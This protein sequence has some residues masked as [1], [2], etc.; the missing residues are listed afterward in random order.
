MAQK[1][2]EIILLRQLAGYLSN[3]IL[4]F[5]PAGDLLYF[6]EPAEALLGQRFEESGALT[7]AQWHT[8][9]DATHEDGTPIPRSERPLAIALDQR[10]PSL[11]TL[12]LRC[13]D[14]RRKKMQAMAFPLDGQGGRLLGAA[15]TFWEEGRRP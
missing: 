11:A 1:A 10:Q 9:I 8:L 5:D 7:P 15:I 2:V 14:G 12:W 4:L 6:N 13:A 3:P